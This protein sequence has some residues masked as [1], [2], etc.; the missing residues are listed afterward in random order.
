MLA[1][2]A[3]LILGCQQGNQ[4]TTTAAVAVT[5]KRL[6]VSDMSNGEYRNPVLH[7]DY[8]DPDVVAV[9][10]NYYMTA[11]SFNTAPGLPV[12]H[13]TDLV[14]WKLI[15]YALPKQVPLDHFA[16]PRHG[17]GVWAPNIRFH[18]DKFWI[19]YPDPDFGI[20][21]TTA[22]DPAGQ[23]SAPKLILPGQG[24]IDPTPLWD[25]D[26]KAYLLHAWAKSRAGFN[27][28]LSLREMAPDTGWVS[29]DYTNVVDGNKL[30][31]YRTIEGPKFYKRNGYYYIFA[32]A[33]GVETGWQTVFRAKAISGPYEARVVMDQGN[34]L[35]NG[36]H[37]GAWVHTD[38]NEDWFIHFQSR[39][40]YGRIVHLQ[41][42][43][44][45]SDWPV[46]GVDEDG[47]GVGEPVYTHTKPKT[48]KPGVIA[49]QP[50]T[51]EFNGK[52]LGIQWQWNANSNDSWYR[53]DE[54]RGVLRLLGQPKVEK[55]GDNLWMTPSLLLQ[56]L[57]APTFEV[58]TKFNL[59]SS[60]KNAEGGL[61]MFGED[62][63]YVGIKPI[64]GQTHLVYGHCGGARTGC[65]ESIE[66]Y[67]PI[68]SESV[69]LRYIVASDASVIFS[70]RTDANSRFTV[71]G[72]QFSAVRGRWVGAKVGLFSLADDTAAHIDV[73]YLRFLPQQ[74]K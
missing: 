3:P 14:N 43:T 72:E 1:L 15:N 27:N 41:P 12:L 47:D 56:K 35:I 67:G 16:T 7:L 30:P 66:D 24:L 40:A 4:T 42:L 57:P 21:V 18:D 52:E 65:D 13:S 70:Y 44:W 68:K 39:K 71:V 20:Y 48:D 36:P 62:Y 50:T 26:G 17:E 19:F 37:Q 51:D 63:A 45:Q 31:G 10:G 73:D 6:W 25:D 29:E 69:E 22:T 53:M 58:R 32:P 34:T 38:E 33:G 2:L 60:S 59:A 8:S 28:V 64:D 23:W 9:D 61:L 11:S 54:S 46:I 49:P 5:D 55:T 74:R